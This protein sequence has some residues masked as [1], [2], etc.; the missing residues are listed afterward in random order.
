MSMLGMLDIPPTKGVFQNLD[1]GAPLT[2]PFN[3]SSFKLSRTVQWSAQGAASQAYST[4]QFANGE[5]DTLSMTLLL[6]TSETTTSVLPTTQLIYGWS[7]PMAVAAGSMR[8]P[9]LLFTWGLFTFQGVVSRAEF[10]FNLFDST[11]APKRAMV[12]LEMLGRAFAR[13]TPSAQFF[14]QAPTPPAGPRLGG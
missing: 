3:P 9:C 2:L 11:G 12:T 7:L 6:D 5:V 10:D 1:G 13:G 8:P 4:L 14:G